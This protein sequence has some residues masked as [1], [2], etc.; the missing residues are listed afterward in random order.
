MIRNLELWIDDL[1]RGDVLMVS[2][3]YKNKCLEPNFVLG[4]VAQRCE[5]RQAY[6]QLYV[7]EGERSLI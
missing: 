6:N 4:L 1:S 5:L 2:N 7:I 3:E